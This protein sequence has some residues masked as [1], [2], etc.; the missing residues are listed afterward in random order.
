MIQFSWM[1]PSKGIVPHISEHHGIDFILFSS[2]WFEEEA[3][4]KMRQYRPHGALL[5]VWNQLYG[6]FCG[7]S[8]ASWGGRGGAGGG[9]LGPIL[10]EDALF[11][12]ATWGADSPG[13]TPLP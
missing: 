13:D 10:L 2:D 5:V 8:M 7:S 9:Y 11:P 1:V 3:T 12:A 6:H 4:F